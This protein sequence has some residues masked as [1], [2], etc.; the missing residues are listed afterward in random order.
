MDVHSGTAKFDLTLFMLDDGDHISGALEFNTDLFD[1]TT[2]E[3]MLQ[4][5]EVL[6]TAM[7]ANPE[8]SV[9][10]APMLTENE[11]RQIL[12]EWNQTAA[13]YPQ[14]KCA[15]QLFEEQVERT[16]TTLALRLYNSDNQMQTWTYADLNRRANQLAHYLQRC[17]VGPEILVGLCVDRSLEMVV[18]LLGVLKAGGAYVPLDPT[19]PSERL[20][21][22]LTD[23]Q[24]KVLL[25]QKHLVNRLA[26]ADSINSDRVICLD[27]DWPVIALEQDHN[28]VSQ[29]K[30]ENLAYVIYTSGSTG[31]PKGAMI[32]QRGLVNYLT[33][34][35]RAYP[36]EQGQG[37]P[38]HSSISFDLTITSLLSPL[39]SGRAATLL[40]EGL[41]VE[42]LGETLRRDAAAGEIPYSL[43]KITPA[44]LQLLGE[45]LKPEE[46]ADRT[47]SFIIGG[48]NLTVDHVQH[49]L[50]YS[51]NTA[52]VNEYGP[53]ETVVG[54]CVYWTPQEDPT[55]LRDKFRSGIIPIGRPII[56]TQLYVLDG[57]QQPVPVGV[58][59]ELYIG[60]VGV[61]RGYLNR[62][63]LTAEKFIPN[64]FSKIANRSSQI[65]EYSVESVETNDRLYRTGDLVRYLPDGNLECLGRI[66]FQV[67]IRG[68]RVELGEIEAV[69]SR[70]PDVSEVVVWVWEEA[71]FKNLVAYIVPV[72]PTS[73]PTEEIRQYL[74][75][76]LPEYML[77]AAFVYLDALPLTVNGKVDRK[78]LPRPDLSRTERQAGFV[79]PRTPQEEIV[80]GIFS[81]VLGVAKIGADDNFFS[82][83]GHSLLAT[84]VVSRLR[85]TFQ[86]ELPLRSLFEAPTVAGLVA[87]VETY[88][89]SPA[90]MNI[91]GSSQMLPIP[92]I[93]RNPLTGAPDQPVIPSFAQQRLLVLDQ[94]IPNSPLYNIPTFVQVNG[95]LDLQ[96]LELSL[97]QVIRRHE[98][99]RTIFKIVDGRPMQII[100]ADLTL[101]VPVIDLTSLSEGERRSRAMETARQDALQ[102][103]DLSRGPLIRLSLVK[104][105]E[106]EYFILLNTHHII[107]DDWSLSVFIREILA[108]YMVYSSQAVDPVTLSGN[109]DHHRNLLDAMLPGLPLQYADFSVWQRAWLQ[110]EVLEDQLN[111]WKGQLS[112][113]PPLLELPTDRPR[114][115]VQTFN[116]SQVTFELSPDQL[117]ALKTLSRQEG[118]TLFMTLLAAFQILLS[119]YSGQLEF[120]I[121]TPIANRTRSEVEGLIGFF[122]NTLV[123]R[124]DLS[125]EPDFLMLLK[126]VREIALSAY[127]HQDLPF[128]MLVDALGLDRD[129]GY[130]PLFQVMFVH[131]NAPRQIDSPVAD[132]ALKPIELHE[133]V[134]RFDLTLMVVEVP[135]AGITDSSED[136]PIGLSASLEYNTDLFDRATIERMAAYFTRLIENILVDPRQQVSGLRLMSAAEEREIVEE[137]SRGRREEPDV[138]CVQQIFEEQVKRTPEAEAVVYVNGEQEQRLSYAELNHKANQLA[139]Y[140]RREGVGAEQLV[141]ICVERS[142]EMVIGLLGILKAG[143]AYLPLDP[144]YPSERLGYMLADSGVG[145]LLTQAKLVERLPIDREGLR[146]IRLDSEWGEIEHGGDGVDDA[147]AVGP[148]NLAYMIYTSGSTGRPKGVLLRHGGLTNLVKEQIRGFGVDAHSCVLQFASFSFDASVSEIFMGLLSGGRLVMASQEQ[149]GS[150]EGLVGVMKR[151][152]VTTVTLPP[153]LLRV[154]DEGEVGAELVELRTLISAGEACGK[155]LAE[156]W[157]AGRQMFNAYGPTEATIGPTYY[158]VEMEGEKLRGVPAGAK[159]TPIGK[160]IANMEVYVMD[161][162]RRVAPVGVAGEIYLGGIGLAKGY[163][164][165]PEL[166]GEKFVTHP[167]RAGERLYRTGDLGRWLPDGN[168]EYL[169]RIDFQVKVRG[170]RIELGE[171]EAVLA[172]HPDVRAAA[173]WVWEEHGV[174]RIVA[175]YVPRDPTQAPSRDDLREFCREALP[176]YMLPVVFIPVDELLLTANG[177]VNRAGMV[178]KYS[179]GAL[180][181]ESEKMYIPPQSQREVILAEIWSA[182]LGVERVSITDNFFELGGDSIL[183]FQ[184]ISRARKEG[185]EITYRQL[186]ENPT[187]QELATVVSE[188]VISLDGSGQS[189]AE[190]GLV[191]GAAPLSPAQSWFFDHYESSLNQYNASIMVEVRIK[192]DLSLVKKTL[193]YLLMHHDELRARFEQGERGWMQFTAGENIQEIPFMVLDLSELEPEDCAQRIVAEADIAHRSLDI[194]R[195]P[196]MS[197]LYFD[198]GKR[199]SHRLLFIFHHLIFDGVSARIILEDFLTIYLQLMNGS[200]VQLPPKTTSYKAWCEKLHETAQLDLIRNQLDY[201]L[202]NNQRQPNV[203]PI[204]YPDVENTFGSVDHITQSLSP[205]DTAVLVSRIPGRYKVS[206][207]AVLLTA[208]ARTW[209][210]LFGLPGIFLELEGHGREQIDGTPLNNLDVSRTVGWFTSIFPL[211][212]QLSEAATVEMQLR[213]VAERLNEIPERGIGFGLLRYLSDDER[214]RDLMAEIPQPQINFNYLGQFEASGVDRQSQSIDSEMLPFKIVNEPAGMEQSPLSQRT[215][216]LDVVAVINAN[217]LGVRWSFSRE[218]FKQ[219]TVQR[220]AAAFM[221][222]LWSMITEAATGIELIDMAPD[223][224]GDEEHRGDKE[225]Q[226]S[227]QDDALAGMEDFG[228]SQ[229]DLADLLGAIDDSASGNL[230]ENEEN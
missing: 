67:K 52:L 49:W 161:G 192:L 127:A 195:P 210:A 24:S 196:L 206:V 111:Y 118:A 209:K 60:G 5:F 76:R 132:L 145:I 18:G 128:E 141:G 218:V 184:V 167:W 54:C 10:H 219:E 133:G 88:R 23:S 200:P 174:K 40:P 1:A 21:F 139:G 46:A 205:A 32:E 95:V 162:S 215:T 203:L 13:P 78:A 53:T 72:E 138:R 193:R 142:L 216:L 126:R 43:I 16:P 121:G 82:L 93:P 15:H 134:A 227:A 152:G 92:T 125:G 124:S 165:Q 33:W 37:S 173:V 14:D 198:M 176:E 28:P 204:D 223:Q 81:D 160:P 130:N 47:R 150:V 213:L 22:M 85:D 30:P 178:K 230:I 80:A 156:R 63:E 225:H 180:L 31:L 224:S 11:R 90:M 189:S 56:N 8:E 2:I 77:P 12:I 110:G 197:A 175:Y 199:Q 103:F 19:Y 38:V 68:F 104:L 20:A 89:R 186:F 120:A 114:P 87:Q 144:S 3:R 122:V 188:G 59:G 83:G 172:G 91:A 183:S 137:W 27:D 25:T 17:G 55:S 115:A 105:T 107:S 190:Q 57:F 136:N 64:P 26:G 149:L 131:Q 147:S 217:Q 98:S 75:D 113:L 157:G 163:L 135:L 143:G 58:P 71:G 84:Q 62:P 148:E 158:R 97:N 119:R 86:V 129:L 155:D 116:G 41:G 194:N 4:H 154:M 39:V 228:W 73:K 61:G 106:S 212:L 66:D 201:W 181:W 177:K 187:I 70:H 29:A 170:F 202:Q 108:G 109:K 166:T 50:N 48:E 112:G 9:V 151:T 171:I 169:G 159:T 102:P 45:Q 96:A 74:L 94:L 191:T 164:N 208:L 123:L 36:L 117:T 140:L 7:L 153:S 214:I 44:H 168:L 34:C 79:A 207:Y 182:L 99:L 100:L 226:S 6:L 51:P 179:P 146:L 42:L 221:D 101:S 65:E 35:Q 222:E 220:I 211:N 69:I 185:L 229:D